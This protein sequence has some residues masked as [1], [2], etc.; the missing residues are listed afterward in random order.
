LERLQK[1]APIFEAWSD[2]PWIVEGAAVRVSLVCSAVDPSEPKFLD[3]RATP[4]INIDLTMA[5]SDLTKAWQLDENT[6][7]AFMG[8]TKGGGFDVPGS[9]AREWLQEPS[10]P[11][12]RPNADVL[13]PWMNGLDVTRRP[14]D[15]WIID[16]GWTMSEADVEPRAL[17][18]LIATGF[19]EVLGDEVALSRRSKDGRVSWRSTRLA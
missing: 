9:L 3:G 6:G 17:I 5:L 8:D 13:K 10:N 19:L 12:G 15:K 11:N 2:E 16:F 14:R 4:T 1:D 18:E 7:V